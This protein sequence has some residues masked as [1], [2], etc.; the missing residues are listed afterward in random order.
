M[1]M[2]TSGDIHLKLKH[3]DT[4]TLVSNFDQR[5]YGFIKSLTTRGPQI[6]C[7]FVTENM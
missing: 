5:C 4:N 6:L 7:C 1:N 2:N 3:T